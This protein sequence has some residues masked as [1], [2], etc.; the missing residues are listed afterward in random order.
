MISFTIGKEL[1]SMR[2]H[3][4]SLF[5]EDQHSGPY[6]LQ[7]TDK[8]LIEKINGLTKQKR[9][10]WK[11][12]GRGL[13]KSDPM[14]FCCTFSSSTEAREWLERTIMRMDARSY[15]LKPVGV[16]YGWEVSWQSSGDEQLLEGGA[17]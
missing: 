14:I 10:P 7:T 6:R 1:K 9:S 5:A 17:Q 3:E 13:K 16:G 2:K 11:I 8:R 15:T 12:V 4:T